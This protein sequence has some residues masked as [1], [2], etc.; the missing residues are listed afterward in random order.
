[1]AN[2]ALRLIGSTTEASSDAASEELNPREVWRALK[3]RKL[4][5]L[6]PVALITLGVFFWAKQQPPLYTGE[7]LLHVQTRDA[8]VIQVEGVVEEMI[9]DPATIESEIEFLSSPAFSQRIVEKLGLMSDPEFAPWLK[10][11][12][13]DPIGTVLELLNPMRYIPEDWLSLRRCAT[14][15]ALDPEIMQLNAAAAM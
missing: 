15:P 1:M 10:E 3:R 6:T 14:A 7:A 13:P 5:L 8:Q 4:A 12:E 11:S 9:A 2:E